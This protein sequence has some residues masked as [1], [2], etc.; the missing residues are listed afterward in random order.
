MPTRTKSL[1]TPSQRDKFIDKDHAIIPA[2]LPAWRAA[3]SEVNLNLVVPIGDDIWRYWVPEPCVVV[4]SSATDRLKRY[5]FRW[6]KIRDAWYHL[7]V[8]DMMRQDRLRPLKASEWRDYL[9]MCPHVQKEIDTA[10][11]TKRSVQIVNVMKIFRDILGPQNDDDSVSASWLGCDVESLEGLAWNRV[12]A[13]IAWDLAEVGFR[14][15]LS[16]LD[17]FLVPRTTP[18]DDLER[19]E[20]EALLSAVFPADRGLVIKTFPTTQNGLAA[21][22]SACRTAYLEA[23]R[24][25][26]SRW[27][28]VPEDLRNCAPL[29]ST[30][31]VIRVAK[32]EKEMALFYCTTFFRVTGRAPVLP[33]CVPVHSEAVIENE[34]PTDTRSPEN[35]NALTDNRPT[36]ALANIGPVAGVVSAEDLVAAVITNPTSGDAVNTQPIPDV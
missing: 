29:T 25:V 16:E 2:L 13:E 8:R 36:A 20:R 17:R 31:S 6:L 35:A 5:V 27:P 4:G 3:L 19:A 14:F 30:T 24:Q 18:D 33:R 10:P 21:S 23:L 26:L 7:L 32:A 34:A 9:N 15:E 1:L 22:L 11:N 28:E 12:L